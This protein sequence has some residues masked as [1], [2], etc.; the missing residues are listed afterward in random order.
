MPVKV[1]VVVA[2]V[3][4][5]LALFLLSRSAHKKIDAQGL[6]THVIDLR[7]QAVQLDLIQRLLSSAR[8]THQYAREQLDLLTDQTAPIV[9]ELSQGHAEAQ[10]QGELAELGR[11]AQQIYAVE[12]RYS[13]FGSGDEH[14]RAV[15]QSSV[16]RLLVLERALLEK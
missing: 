2:A 7:S 16:K 9:S 12:R 13:S 1:S 6:R 10:F 15:L 11:I 8:V 5:V 14:Y 3:L 4:L